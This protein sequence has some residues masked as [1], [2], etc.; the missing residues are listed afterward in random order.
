MAARKVIFSG[1]VTGSV[2]TP[3][4]SEDLPI[5]LAWI[6]EQAWKSAHYIQNELSD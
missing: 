1:A 4:V 3:N 2:Q 5:T 6:A